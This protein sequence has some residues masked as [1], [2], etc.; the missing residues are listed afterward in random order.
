MFEANV[1][2]ASFHAKN[3]FQMDGHRLRHAAFLSSYVM[4]CSPKAKLRSQMSVTFAIKRANEKILWQ[5]G[6]SE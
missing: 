3:H 4:G 5:S 6:K 1:H 2:M